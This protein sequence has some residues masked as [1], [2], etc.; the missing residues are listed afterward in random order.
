M[1][2][3]SFKSN[4]VIGLQESQAC[5]GT[6]QSVREALSASSHSRGLE[7]RAQAVTA[8]LNAVKAVIGGNVQ[9]SQSPKENEKK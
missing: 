7:G 5:E 9:S 4:R 3:K 2:E 8:T 1:T 6:L